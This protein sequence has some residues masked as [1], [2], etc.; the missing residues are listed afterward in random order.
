[1]SNFS[2]QRSKE[3]LR[4]FLF[5][6][7]S[8]GDDDQ[9]SGLLYAF[10]CLVPLYILLT[11]TATVGNSLILFALHKDISLHLPSKTLLRTLAISDLCVGVIGLPLPIIFI[12]SALFES[13]DLCRIAKILLYV[14]NTIFSS[15]SL[16]TLTAISVDRLLALLLRFRYRQVV[17]VK[18][19]RVIVILFWLTTSVAGVLTH[20]LNMN[21]YFLI[22][23]VCSIN[24]LPLL[25]S[26]Y[27]YSRI[28]L[29]VRRK[30][31]IQLQSGSPGV[32]AN[33]GLNMARYT[34]TVYSALWIHLTLV[35]CYFPSGVVMVLTA[36]RGITSCLLLAQ[37]WAFFL[38]FL[39]SSLNPVLFCWKIREVRQTMKEIIRQLGACFLT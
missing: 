2:D 38:V 12:L 28:F 29:T 30:R 4:R 33:S 9:G 18:R 22:F 20:V 37:G 19:V 6:T 5:C 14:F 36:V 21:S 13:W 32:T 39:N 24:I 7:L 25:I 3:A 23:G 31:Q 16:L 10:K 8:E 17:T 27:S 15:V 11:L 34:K 35:T 1:M 26:T